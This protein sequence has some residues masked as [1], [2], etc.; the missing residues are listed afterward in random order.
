MV[1]LGAGSIGTLPK[2]LLRALK[3]EE[4]RHDTSRGARGQTVP[5]LESQSGSKAAMAAVVVDGGARRSRPSSWG[6]R[7]TRPSVSCWPR[8]RSP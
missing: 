2:R 1:T 6:S 8:R 5:A 3:G 7:S 4:P